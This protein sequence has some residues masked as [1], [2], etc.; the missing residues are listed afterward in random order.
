M[1]KSMLFSLLDKEKV[2]QNTIS[3]HST[4]ELDSIYKLLRQLFDDDKEADIKE[5]L[6]KVEVTPTKPC[7]EFIVAVLSYL[8]DS[9]NSSRFSALIQ[10]AGTAQKWQHVLFL[11]NLALSINSHDIIASSSKIQALEKLGNDKEELKSEILRYTMQEDRE[12]GMLLYLADIFEA[13]GNDEDAI[14]TIKRA[15]VRAIKNK[16]IK[17]I[18]AATDKLLKKDKNS[19]SYLVETFETPNGKALGEKLEL[20]FIDTYKAIQKTDDPALMLKGIKLLIASSPKNAKYKN[21]L[22]DIYK[23][24]YA[25][26]SRLDECL[27]I[28]GLSK[29]YAVD[30]NKAI[31]SFEKDISIDKGTF[32]Y[33][34][35][36]GIGRVTSVDAENIYI[37]FIKKRGHKMS[38][39]MALTSLSV[40]DKNHIWVLKAFVSKEKLNNRFKNDPHWGVIT[41]L[42]SDADSF[43]SMKRELVPDILNESE[44]QSF[45]QNAK[46]IVKTDPYIAMSQDSNDTYVLLES[47]VSN[48]DKLFFAFKQETNIFN[49]IKIVRTAISEHISLESEHFLSMLKYFGQTLND[50]NIDLTYLISHIFLSSLWTGK[51]KIQEAK[52]YLRKSDMEVLV[53]LPQEK[54]PVYFKDL[55]DPELKKYFINMIASFSTSWKEVLDEA[56]T[57]APFPQIEKL[58]QK[59]GVDDFMPN[60]MKKSFFIVKQN[61]TLFVY[62]LKA[63]P[64]AEDWKDAGKTEYDIILAELDVYNTFPATDKAKAVYANLF[65]NR[66]IF[67]FIENTTDEFILSN[68]EKQVSLSQSIDDSRKQE[69]KHLVGLKL[70]KSEETAKTQNKSNAKVFPKEL[71]CLASSYDKKKLELEH[72]IDVEIPQ[73]AKD[74]GEARELGDLRENAEFQYAKDKQKILNA[75]MNKLEEEIRKAKI[76]S[77]STFDASSVSFGTIVSIK[78]EIE[79]AEFTYTILGPW[80]S[81]PEKDIISYTAPAIKEIYGAKEGETV[82]FFLNGDE[83]KWTVLKIKTV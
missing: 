18:K 9:N 82:E 71:L 72:L 1:D 46:K 26:S 43:K 53:H 51:D 16:S 75:T 34:Q 83:K 10:K 64:N 3:D 7:S 77:P 37:D 23:K 12:V 76:V 62:L 21:E 66:R 22:L 74:I 47:P 69:V 39:E 48:E 19:L 54:L 28:S 15:L 14:H 78:D 49:K 35:S 80:E 6:E 57:I 44:W 56:Y 58:M 52:A 81:E 55:E 79:N 17:D 42:K 33:H 73:N 36:H 32:V 31:Q 60:M 63:Y 70:N 41:L 67:S 59:R 5:I 68:I 27:S 50:K 29:D 24:L 45:L 30:L 61:P 8:E 20:A 4:E 2:L 11:S 13:E 38:H 25:S 40:L 65:E